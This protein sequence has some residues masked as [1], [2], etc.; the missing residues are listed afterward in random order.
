MD[1]TTDCEASGAFYRVKEGGE[2]FNAFVSGKREE[3]TTPI[4]I[5]ERST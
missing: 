1:V 3:G 5:G 2:F 4:L